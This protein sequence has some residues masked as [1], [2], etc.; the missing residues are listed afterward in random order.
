MKRILIAFAYTTIGLLFS[1]LTFPLAASAQYTFPSE[2]QPHEGTWLQWPH[3]YTYGSGAD[4]VIGSWVDMVQALHEHERVHIAVYNEEEAGNVIS[5]LNQASVDLTQVDLFTCPSDDFWARDNGPIFVHDEDGNWK[6][7]DWGFNGWGGDTPYLL[8]DAVPTNIAQQIGIPHIDLSGVVLEGGAIEIDG[9]G[10]LIATR[11]SV[12]GPDRN[13]NLTESQ[14]EDSLSYYLGIDQ[15]VWLDG[16]FGG[17][18]DITDQHIDAFARFANS[19][20]L[21]T[22]NDTDLAYWLVSAGDRQIID[23]LTNVSGESYTRINLPL[24][25][26]IVQTTYGQSIGYR[27]SYV[28]FYVAN[29]TVLIPWFNDPMDAVAADILQGVFPERTIVSIDCRNIVAWGGMV[30]CVT[31]QQPAG[32]I[33]NSVP[34]ISNTTGLSP[35]RDGLIFTLAGKQ[36]TNPSPGQPYFEIVNGIAVKK[37]QSH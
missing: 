22:M 1:L 9:N 27:C 26:N 10:T 5:A 32:A 37:V 20:T 8:D 21:V 18:E 6:V 19:Q 30:H 3:D 31:Q 35:L 25:Q 23:N 15:I 34:N 12:T 16:Q 11:S 36:I 13:P 2:D 14:I 4:Y 29:S 28:N 17:T 33:W 7:L 24:T